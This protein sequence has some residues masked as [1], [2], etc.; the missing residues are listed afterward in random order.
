[1]IQEQEATDTKKDK[2]KN[3]KSLRKKLKLTEV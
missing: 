1:M 3:K 2:E